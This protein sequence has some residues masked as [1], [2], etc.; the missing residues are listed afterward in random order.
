MGSLL[1]LSS[2]SDPATWLSWQTSETGIQ[3]MPSGLVAFW[4]YFGVGFLGIGFFG[5]GEEEGEAV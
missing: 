5:A 3:L 4:G 2:A 1:K